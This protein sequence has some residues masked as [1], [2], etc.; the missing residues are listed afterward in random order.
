MRNYT[1]NQTQSRTIACALRLASS[2][3]VRRDVGASRMMIRFKQLLAVPLCV[4]GLSLPLWWLHRSGDAGFGPIVFVFTGRA[5]ATRPIVTGGALDQFSLHKELFILCYSIVALCPFLAVIR[6]LS[7]SIPRLP[8]SIFVSA[9]LIVLVHPFSVL[10]IFSW[11]V[12]RYIYRMGITS[13]RLAALVVALVA[14]V[15]LAVFAAWI[16]G[17]KMGMP[18]KAS[19][20]TS[21]PAPGADS[22]A[23]EG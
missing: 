8:R 10:T 9:S 19:D 20:A 3:K 12:S 13:M 5:F 2:P 6:W 18:N 11:D 14:Y 23:R 1:R 21:K 15:A 16:A 4:V 22:S 17:F 7:R